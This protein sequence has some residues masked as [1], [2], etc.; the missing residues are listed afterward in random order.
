ML[1]KYQVQRGFTLIELMIVVAIIGILAAIALPAYQNYTQKAQVAAALA[2]I[3]GARTAYDVA[4]AEGME[5]EFYT[6][7]NLG[8]VN[9]I[10]NRCKKFEVIAPNNDG[11]VYAALK[12]DM[13]GVGVVEHAFIALE[14]SAKGQWSCRSNVGEKLAPKGCTQIE[15]DL[16]G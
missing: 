15:P 7:K 16:E 5:R 13:K 9:D 2:E 11:S 14:R 4:F 6:P 10:T 1:I 8:L 3:S 12:C